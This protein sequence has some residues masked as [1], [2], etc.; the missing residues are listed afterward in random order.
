[1]AIEVR[2]NPDDAKMF[3]AFAK[4]EA[5]LKELERG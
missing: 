2:F 1:M 5:K 3:Q 4:P